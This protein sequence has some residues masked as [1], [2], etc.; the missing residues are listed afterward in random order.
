MMIASINTKIYNKLLFF[1]K[2]KTPLSRE[3]EQGFEYAFLKFKF[4]PKPHV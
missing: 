3:G 1:L 4:F 2:N